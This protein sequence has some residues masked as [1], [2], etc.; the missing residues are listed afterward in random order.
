MR[1]RI[2]DA[3]RRVA[4]LEITAKGVALL[5]RADSVMRNDFAVALSDW[6]RADRRR[7]ADLLDRFRADLLRTRTDAEGWS[8]DK[9]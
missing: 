6:S 7:L 5:E 3:D 9:A 2:D 1:R 8:V 4:W